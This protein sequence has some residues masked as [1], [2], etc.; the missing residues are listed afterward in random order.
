MKIAVLAWGSLVWDGRELAITADFRPNA[1]A[2]PLNSVASL[3]A[4][5]SRW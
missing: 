2:F 1:R 5:V 4:D 3:E